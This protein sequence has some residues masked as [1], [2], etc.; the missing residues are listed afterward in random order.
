MAIKKMQM[1][2]K[3]IDSSETNLYP[4]T[5]AQYVSMENGQ[6]V[7]E[8]LSDRDSDKY[9]P[10]ITNSSSTFKVGQGDNVDLSSSMKEGAYDSC[11]LKGKTMVNC[12]QE[13]SSKDVVLPYQFTDG[14][15]VTINDT[16]ESGALGVE[17]KGQTLVNYYPSYSKTMPVG[18]GTWR[19]ISTLSLVA[20]LKTNTTYTF[21]NLSNVGVKLNMSTVG[22]NGEKSAI[23]GM[24]TKAKVFTTP[25][26]DSVYKL[27][28][29]LMED[30][31]TE[32][33][34]DTFMVLEG[35]YTNIDVPYFTGMTSCKMPTLY[36]VGKNLFNYADLT[37][38]HV[39]WD[40]SNNVNIFENGWYRESA[41]GVGFRLTKCIKVKPNTRYYVN[42]PHQIHFMQYNANGELIKGNY[43]IASVG[44]VPTSS[45]TY[46][47][48]LYPA[49]GIG[50]MWDETRRQEY[51][52][53][54]ISESEAMTTY[55]PYKSSILSLPEEVVLRSLPNGV[56][57]TFNT[58]TGVYTQ[59]I[60]E[61]QLQ[62]VDRWD[63]YALKDEFPD[64]VGFYTSFE[65]QFG[66]RYG[67]RYN[68][69]GVLPPSESDKLPGSLTENNEVIVVNNTL[70]I[71]LA[72]NRTRLNSLDSNGLKQWLKSNPITLQYQLATPIITKINL[73]STLKSWNTTTH[74]YS[75]IPENTLHPILSHSN[76]SYPVILKPSTKYSIV[77][78]SYS[79][80]HT[81]SA[82]NFNLGGATTST[83]LGNRVTTITTPSTLTS[84]ELVMRGR[85]NKLNNVMIIEGNVVGDEPYFEGICDVK[86]PILLN[87]GK[88]LISSSEEFAFP[89]GT[90]MGIQKPLFNVKLKPNT[91][92]VLSGYFTQNVGANGYCLFLNS[93]NRIFS[94]HNDAY[95]NTLP[96][97]RLQMNVK[98][99]TNAINVYATITANSGVLTGEAIYSHCQLEESPTKTTYE[100]YKSNILSCNGDKIELTE[101]MF[102]QGT[103]IW[104]NV[105]NGTSFEEIKGEAPNRIR[106][107]ELIVSKPNTTY[108]IINDEKQIYQY[109]IL[110]FDKNGCKVEYTQNAWVSNSIV[111][112]TNDTA[113]IGIAIKKSNNYEIAPTEFANINFE[114]REVDK[115]IVLR[116]LP[117]GVCDTLNVETGE[118]VQ[119]IGQ[120]TFDGSENW[121]LMRDNENENILFSCTGF[122]S[123]INVS[124]T[125]SMLCDKIV[126][127]A[128]W[129]YT[130][131]QTS[132]NGIALMDTRKGCRIG[133]V[134][135][136]GVTNI[137]EFKAWLAKN[138]TTIQYE[139]ETPIV[140]TID[141]QGFP[142][143][144]K[145]GH[146]ILSSGSIEQSLT[147]TV[148]YSLSAN[149]TGQINSNSKIIMKHQKQLDDFE[150][151]MLTS[152]VQSAYDKAILQFDYEMQMMSLGGE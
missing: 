46:Y 47:I 91:T 31:A 40:T 66:K 150:A 124:G 18:T 143:A 73:P 61:V 95:A 98:F 4:L 111:T 1:F 105:A 23:A 72:V 8:V 36:T 110:P 54:Y 132:S 99:T 75:E 68:Y 63:R 11:V 79:N 90:N 87:C 94:S 141:V 56:C 128:S 67:N 152:M 71:K 130:F 149:K 145:D 12:I 120:N 103:L 6:T 52:N 96:E 81:N 112:T 121:T 7:Q 39:I 88:N 116:S 74:I 59:R 114:I 15:H 62:D 136:E 131:S 104:T 45:E 101:D 108:R 148:E 16:K 135:S 107:K 142:Y 146:V 58:R 53:C 76:P 20:S 97:N 43:P 17:L 55:E 49:G 38:G 102:E 27:H 139:L 92:Y 134:R 22:S 82:I 122:N 69:H 93:E 29:Y 26:D 86:S 109:L 78:N 123:Y 85:G 64:V 24:T 9:T 127:K 21:I 10:V 138:P 41:D 147:P 30:N 60:G 37:S 44:Y 77:A 83:T 42:F 57:D 14:Q 126:P 32:L 151:M 70:Y 117:N 89:S 48:N 125:P 13:P 19:A 106:T 84:E 5:E 51:Q 133:L 34:W 140:S 33:T 25:T 35:D 28:I 3:N 100:P 115:T 2:R 65:W 118:Y 137:N 50:S 80:N 129:T 144:Y 113:Y 119:R